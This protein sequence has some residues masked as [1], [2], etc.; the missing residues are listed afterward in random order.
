M[1]IGYS[2]YIISALSH[3]KEDLV[4]SVAQTVRVWDIGIFLLFESWP[5]YAPSECL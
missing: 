5:V 1:L 3:P 4:V 2:H